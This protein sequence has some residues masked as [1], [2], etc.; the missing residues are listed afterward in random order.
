MR[1][2][3]SYILKVSKVQRCINRRRKCFLTNEGT[4][5]LVRWQFHILEMFSRKELAREVAEEGPGC[6]GW[7]SRL[8]WYKKT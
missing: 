4:G 8:A 7:E 3:D 5:C 2:I 6:F 1:S